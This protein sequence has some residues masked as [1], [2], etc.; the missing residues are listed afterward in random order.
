MPR[1]GGQHVLATAHVGEQRVQRVGDD[2]L[3]A[4]GGGEVEDEVVLADEI[5][6]QLGVGRAAFDQLSFA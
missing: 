2:Q 5:V 3:D 6:D 4:D 1:G